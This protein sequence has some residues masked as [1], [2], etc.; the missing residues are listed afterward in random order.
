MQDLHKESRYQFSHNEESAL[1]ALF[2][3]RSHRD[4]SDR[5]IDER[6]ITTIIAAGAAT[7]SAHGKQ[8]YCFARFDN[9]QTIKAVVLKF[10]WFAPAVKAWTNILVLGNPDKCVNREYWVVDCAAATQNLLLASQSFG[11]GSLW[12]GIAPVEQNIINFS[13]I[14][15]LPDGLVP[16]SLVALGYPKNEQATA[17]KYPSVEDF[18]IS[19]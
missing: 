16:F 1:E 6:V 8:P 15:T 7:P 11:I 14:V 3:R 4:F 12:M 9:P 18:L 5:A 19:I 2:R 10:P 17:A 13:S